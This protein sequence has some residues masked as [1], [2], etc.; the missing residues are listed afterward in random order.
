MKR[1]ELLIH[2]VACEKLKGLLIIKFQ[3]E[4]MTHCTIF[5]I[6]YSK[7]SKLQKWRKHLCLPSLAEFQGELWEIWAHGII[8]WYNKDSGYSSLQLSK[9]TGLQHQE[10]TVLPIHS[11]IPTRFLNTY[12]SDGL[13]VLDP[14]KELIGNIPIHQLPVPLWEH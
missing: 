1:L 8:L 12:K 4:K 5:I 2:T 3:T 13:P 14:L 9:W 6:C 7:K 11:K 10:K